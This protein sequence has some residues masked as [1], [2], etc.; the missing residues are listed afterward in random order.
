MKSCREPRAL[1]EAL[2]DQA[3]PEPGRTR[4]LRHLASCAEC[5]GELES[6]RRADQALAEACPEHGVQD[7]E[8]ARSVFLGS[9]ARWERERTGNDG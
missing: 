9:V 6:L 2:Q 7:R 5:A 8:A 1:L 4:L 3:L